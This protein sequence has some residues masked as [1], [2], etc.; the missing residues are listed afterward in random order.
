MIL[1][2]DEDLQHVNLDSSHSWARIRYAQ[3]PHLEA[4]KA[5]EVC[6]TCCIS[7]N[8]TKSTTDELQILSPD[9][10]QSDRD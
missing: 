1:N 5:A 6:F 7:A 3:I 4:K 9:E 8:A 2:Q 10:H